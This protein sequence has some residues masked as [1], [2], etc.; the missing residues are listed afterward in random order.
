MSGRERHE[1]V[2]VG[3]A[4]DSGVGRW[5]VGEQ[6]ALAGEVGEEPVRLVAGEVL[7]QA[8]P[9]EHARDHAAAMVK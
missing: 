5:R 1:V 8:R 3:I 7:A 2:V 9:S 6:G 4:A